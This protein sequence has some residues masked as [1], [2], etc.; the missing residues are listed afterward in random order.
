MHD[1]IIN[2]HSIVDIITNSSTVIYTGVT[3]NA[4]DMVRGI[5]KHVLE[6]AD[7]DKTVD[8]LFDISVVDMRAVEEKMNEHD[9]GSP[10]WHELNEKLE[11]NQ[12]SAVLADASAYSKSRIVVSTKGYPKTNIIS[13]LLSQIFYVEEE[14]S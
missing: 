5:I 10:E 1:I 14:Y 4:A 6:I 9:Y 3:D 8:E 7:S 11:G 13:D 12:V 2:P